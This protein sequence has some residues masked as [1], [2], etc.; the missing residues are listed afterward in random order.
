MTIASIITEHSKCKVAECIAQENV[1]ITERDTYTMFS[2]VD[3]S[4]MILLEDELAELIAAN[5]IEES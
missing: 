3:G 1:Q 5:H 4:A 2:F